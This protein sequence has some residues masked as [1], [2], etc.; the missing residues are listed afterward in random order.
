MKNSFS[1]RQPGN[2]RHTLLAGLIAALAGGGTYW[3]Q[4]SFSA[5]KSHPSALDAVK[6]GNPQQ[7][8]EQS[9][10]LLAALREV[11]WDFFKVPRT[12]KQLP[13]R[14][15]SEDEILRGPTAS[16][17]TWP[18]DGQ[19]RPSAEIAFYSRLYARD[20][21]K[22]HRNDGMRFS[23]SGFYIVGWKRGDVTTVPVE[24]IRVRAYPNHQG[25]ELLFP[26]Q[27][28]Y[29]PNLLKIPTLEMPDGQPRTAAQ[30][31]FKADIRAANEPCATCQ[32]P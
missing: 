22:P 4:H 13:D 24:D 26:G 9:R 29:D 5:D 17:F 7:A 10:Q 15:L 18:H 31:K 6:R 19:L 30:R 11:N 2:L 12:L 20:N 28:E 25:Y 3:Y 21:P 14:M 8:V 23:P 1:I 16:S 32:K 27:N